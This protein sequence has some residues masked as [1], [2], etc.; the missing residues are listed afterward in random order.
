MNRRKFLKGATVSLLPIALNGFSI[1]A[2]GRTPLLQTIGR[3]FSINGHVLVVIQLAGG[4]DGLNTVIPHAMS[5]YY[6]N[7]PII[8]IPLSQVIQLNTVMGLHPSLQPLVPLY[9]NG[10]LTIVQGLGYASPNR[11]HF[12]AT[13]IWWTGTD[14]NVVVNTGW[15]G[16]DLQYNYPNYP[17]VLEPNPLALQ[18]GG[19]P[20]LGLQSVNGPMG[21]TIT[22]PN[23][24]YQLIA[25][26]I[27]FAEDPSPNT[28]AGAELRYLRT[29]EQEAIQ[30][31]TTIKAAADRVT[32]RT[33]YPN[34]SLAQ[35]LAIVARL[36]A[37]RLDCPIYLV[38]Q[39]GYDTHSGQG[40]R[41]QT[42][43]N[44]LA[45]A[46]AAFQ[47]DIELLGMADTVVGMTFS[48]FGRRI[49]E[50]GSAGTDHG[51]SSPHFLF[52]TKVVGGFHGPNPDFT[53]IDQT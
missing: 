4:N 41:Q 22:D 12:R 10:K 19:S 49:A 1:R 13:D 51:T 28:P 32:N 18:I 24:F 44:D 8:N 34:S 30:Y 21:V 40:T 17:G 2:L 37:G 33:T 50:N 26:T 39:G 45:S 15:L 43:L 25:G 7:R 9:Q 23:Q 29:I 36:I 16:R 48:E 6:N 53:R 14:S 27:G 35:Q 38:S 31:A 46:I 42:L 47:T 5:Q 52:G 20:S 11:S 3:Q